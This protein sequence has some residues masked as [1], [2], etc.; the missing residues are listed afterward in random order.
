MDA[1]GTGGVAGAQSGH[2]P[3]TDEMVEAALYSWHDFRWTEQE[4]M[5]AAIEAALAVLKGL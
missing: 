5:R 3:V 2:S 4:R 1:K